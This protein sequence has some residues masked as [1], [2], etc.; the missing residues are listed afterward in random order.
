MLYIA[1][2]SKNVTFAS[3]VKGSIFISSVDRYS[4][5]QLFEYKWKS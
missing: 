5:K 2:K 3:F 4:L 1:P